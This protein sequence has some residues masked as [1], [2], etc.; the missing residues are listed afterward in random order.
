ML[1]CEDRS[2]GPCPSAQRLTGA[3]AM[4]LPLCNNG[5]DNPRITASHPSASA[6]SDVHFAS[7]GA[8]TWAAQ[9]MTAA[10]IFRRATERVSFPSHLAKPEVGLGVRPMIPAGP[11]DGNGNAAVILMGHADEFNFPSSLS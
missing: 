2:Q 9:E 6:V 4:E 5:G 3:L 8:A 11:G 7:R 10:S 1:G